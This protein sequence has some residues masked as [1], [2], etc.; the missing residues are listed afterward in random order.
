VTKDAKRA[1]GY[2]PIWTRDEKTWVEI[3]AQLLNKPFFLGHSLA[4][5]VGERGLWPGM[6]GDERIVAFTRVG[7]TVQL[8]ARNTHAR[9]PEGTPLARAVAESYSD[10]L[11]ATVPLAAAP[12]PDRKSLL[13]D[14]MAL[15][16][17]DLQGVQTQLEATFRLPY[18]LDRPNSRMERHRSTQDA[19]TLTIRSHYAV[20]KLPAPPVMLPGAPPPNPAALPQPPRAVPDARSFFLAHAYT[21]SPL[22]PA[23]MKTRRADPR[24]GYFTTPYVNFGDDTSGDRRVHLT[25]RWR[26]EK[27]DP[28]AA[29]S[30]PKEPIRVVMDR[31]IPERWRAAVREGI[32][33]WNGAFERA[34]FK[35]AVRVEQQPEDADW[36]TTEGTRMLAVRWFAMEG[37]GATAVGPS[38]GDPRSGEILRGAAIIPENWVRFERGFLQEWTPVLPPAPPVAQRHGGHHDHTCT[39]ADDALEQTAFGLSLLASRGDLV[40]D[41]P[42]ANAFVADSL[43]TVVAHEVGHALGLRHNFRASTSVTRA[44]LRDKAFT[45][46]RGISSSVM[47]YN[48]VNL[49]LRGEAVAD[50]LMP[51][52][53]AYDLWAIEWGYREFAA[54]EESAGLSKLL[55]MSSRDPS[56][57]YATD[58]DTLANDPLVARYDQGD[59]PMAFAA[60]QMKLARELWANA[61]TRKL[62]DD[63]D[64]TLNRRLL[65]RGLLRFGQSLPIVARYVGG[66]YTERTVAGTGKAV[67]TPV[68]AA[69]QRQALTMI[70]SDVLASDSFRFDAKFMSRLGVDHNERWSSGQLNPD[71][72]LPSAVA[73]LQRAALDQ[74]MSDALAQRLADAEPKV[75]QPRTLL[76]YAEVQQRLRSAVWS[77]LARGGDIDSLR[78]TL[79]REHLRRLIAG[80]LR[81]A[82][83]AATDVRSAYRQEVV[84]LDAALRAARARKGSSVATQA[85][86]AESQ[87]ALG[88][89]MRAMVTKPGG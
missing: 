67:S 47:D 70:V 38:Q 3:P 64:L 17:G 78:R 33:M 20:P 76:S 62:V 53:G 39:H 2:L 60:R 45:A 18:A 54:G 14:A 22:P 63:D 13:V 9:A 68:P 7:D 42:Q 87:A 80:L 8:I 28:A 56:L 15:L 6:M 48:P 59:D 24:V 84:A 29:V 73:A 46:T 71:F 52:L 34:G 11:L 81:P 23:P 30:E 55:A 51:G 83:S 31:N 41:G 88:D 69:Q 79:Q 5:G 40:L 4:S 74:L 89:A 16:G 85:H 19:T 21:L 44:Q 37:P 57:A 66:S 35:N 77:E 75:E 43:R 10:S 61:Q 36:T 32:E 49:P 86:L 50:Y 27:K 82:S 12:H 1:D 72:S 65:Q 25:Q 58:E 26:L